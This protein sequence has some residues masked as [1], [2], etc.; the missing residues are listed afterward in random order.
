[1]ALNIFAWDVGLKLICIKMSAC[2]INFQC[3]VCINLAHVLSSFIL[4]ILNIFKILLSIAGCDFGAAILSS[5]WSRLEIA[6]VRIR[7]YIVWR[8][9]I[10]L[11][12]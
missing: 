1:V 6:A 7:K 9:K 3:G 12:N 11:K 10:L 5:L 8:K 4:S 2:L